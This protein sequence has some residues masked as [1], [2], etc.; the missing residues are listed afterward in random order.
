VVTDW[1]L[2]TT[3]EAQSNLQGHHTDTESRE[4]PYNLEKESKYPPHNGAFWSHW[5]LNTVQRISD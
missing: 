1:R 4:N 2:I 5:N 3:T